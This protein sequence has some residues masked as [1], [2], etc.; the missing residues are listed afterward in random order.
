V[1]AE[2]RRRIGLVDR[3]LFVN[4]TAME[5]RLEDNSFFQRLLAT[6]AT[7]FALLAL[8]LASIGLYGLMSYAVARR[9]KEVGIRMALGAHPG[10]VVLDV[11]RETIVLV[12]TG[13]FAGLIGAWGV[14]RLLA[15]T[16][17]GVS[18]MDPLSLGLAIVT[19][20][21]VSLLAG[22]LPARRAAAVSPTTALGAD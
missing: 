13:M 12:A 9:S 21:V 20:A 14:T 8:L 7:V 6:I 22:Y 19:L 2:A 18:A 17:F 4:V 11:L 15:T 1:L 16:L 10:N 3:N 5:R